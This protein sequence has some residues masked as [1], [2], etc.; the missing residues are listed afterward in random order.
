MCL[1]LSISPTLSLFFLSFCPPAPLAPALP[2]TVPLCLSAPSPSLISHHSHLLSP[3]LLL[4]CAL[5]LCLSSCLPFFA[6]PLSPIPLPLL[7]PVHAQMDIRSNKCPPSSGWIWSLELFDTALHC[8]YLIIRAFWEACWRLH[9]SWLSERRPPLI[10]A[11]LRLWGCNSYFK[12]RPAEEKGSSTTLP[13]HLL[14][15]HCEV[16]ELA[17]SFNS[18]LK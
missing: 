2:L 5:S 8:S 9:H 1:P 11:S 7:C 14:N 4:C 3:V 6:T 15:P 13:L 10:T 12:V 17:S 18:T 16:W